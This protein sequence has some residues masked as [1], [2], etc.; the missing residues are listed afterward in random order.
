MR[1]SGEVTIVISVREEPAILQQTQSQ[2][3]L[4]LDFFNR[5]AAQEEEATMFKRRS[6]IVGALAGSALTGSHS[7]AQP[8]QATAGIQ[9]K[10]HYALEGRIAAVDTGA[11]TVTVISADGTRRVLNV[12]PLAAN[13]SSTRVGDYVVLGIEDTRTFVLSSPGVQTPASRAGS[14]AVAVETNQTA[15]GGR[16]SESI[17]NW[18][19]VGVDPGANT[20]TLVNPGGGEVRTFDVTSDVGRQQLPRVKRGDSLT[21]INSQLVVASITPKA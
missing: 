9:T 14:V 21:A 11:R 4:A 3:Q 20:I 5:L 10:T 17:A 6:L 2:G 1:I 7:F 8:D 19:I 16:L 18:T 15:A 12:S 13:I